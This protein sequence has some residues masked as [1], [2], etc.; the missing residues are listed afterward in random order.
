MRGW[1]PQ[2]SANRPRQGHT[3]TP[4]PTQHAS[5]KRH[6]S[7][8]AAK[9]DVLEAELVAKLLPK[10]MSALGTCRGAWGEGREEVVAPP[11]LI[12]HDSGSK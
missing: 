1:D 10:M 7:S 4:K 11:L 9:M 8:A 12:C 2:T 5:E 6:R 3:R